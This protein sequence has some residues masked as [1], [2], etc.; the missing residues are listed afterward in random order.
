MVA[1]TETKVVILAAILL[2]LASLASY[3]Q[4]KTFTGMAISQVEDVAAPSKL[5]LEILQEKPEES[6]IH[7][8]VEEIINKQ[9]LPASLILQP[10]LFNITDSFAPVGATFPC[11]NTVTFDPAR[12]VYQF[13]CLV[14]NNPV[15]R[16]EIDVGHDWTQKG[17]ITIKEALSN[18]YLVYAGGIS[19]RDINGQEMGPYYFAYSSGATIQF[20]HQL[21]PN[22]AVRLWYRDTLQG[23]TTEKVYDY[24][25]M[26]KTLGLHAY[27]YN[28]RSPANGNY[29]YLFLAPTENTGNPRRVVIPYMDLVNM[30][31]FNNNNNYYF[32]TD[33]IDWSKSN[34][35]SVPLN[36]NWGGTPSSPT[37]ILNFFI[38]DYVPDAAG[39]VPPFDDTVYIT[40]STDPYDVMMNIHKSKPPYRDNVNPMVSFD[41]ETFP[42]VMGSTRS[43]S[44]F[45]NLGKILD[46]LYSFGLRDLWIT[47][48]DD[49]GSIDN[50][51]P[52]E[53]PPRIQ[54]GGSKDLKITAQNAQRY[55]Y[56]LG[57]YED[58]T[59]MQN[60]STYWN[61]S[62]L[63][64][65]PDETPR[66]S[67][68]SPAGFVNYR[69]RPELA[70]YYAS[71]NSPYFYDDTGLSTMYI[72]VLVTGPFYG[73]IDYS[74]SA[75][76]DA[77]TTKGVF[78]LNR[79]VIEYIR[80]VYQNPLGGEATVH[81]LLPISH[82][83]GTIETQE[84]EQY[85]GE[86]GDVVPD[87]ELKIVRPKLVGKGMGPPH[88]W[89]GC[90]F[91]RDAYTDPDSWLG[92]IG[93]KYR[94]TAVAYGR[95]GLVSERFFYEQPIPCTQTGCPF[96]YKM[97]KVL[98]KEYFMMKELQKQY[99]SANDVN[100]YYR[101]TAGNW[102]D[103]KQMIIENIELNKTQLREEYDNGL[104]VHVNRHPTNS[105][106]V[107][108][109]NSITYTLPPNS[110]IAW[111]ANI[112]GYNNYGTFL[113]FSALF[114]GRRVDY[115]NSPLYVMADGRGVL[116]DFGN[117]QTTYFK[118]ITSEVNPLFTVTE[119]PQ[120]NF[121]NFQWPITAFGGTDP[122][123]TTPVWRLQGLAIDPS[124][125]TQ[126]TNV[127]FYADGPQGFG[128]FI[129]GGVANDPR[130]T[131]PEFP[132]VGHGF[133]L[134]IP[135][136]RS[137]IYD[138]R[139][140]AIYGYTTDIDEGIDMPFHVRFI[141]IPT[142]PDSTPP[143]VYLLSPAN[144]TEE[145]A[146]TVYFTA[147]ARDNVALKNATLYISLSSYHSLTSQE[148]DSRWTPVQTVEL[149]PHREASVL[150]KQPD[151]P[152]EA[153]FDWNIKVCD[154]ANNCAFARDNNFVHLRYMTK[155]SIGLY[156]PV[157]SEVVTNQPVTFTAFISSGAPLIGAAL[158]TFINNQWIVLALNSTLTQKEETV[159]F[160]LPGVPDGVYI[161]NVRA[162]NV[163]G[164]CERAERGYFFQVLRDLPPVVTL[165]NPPPNYQTTSNTII[166]TTSVTDNGQLRDASLYADYSGQ[167][168]RVQTV[169]LSG[170]SASPS[171][172]VNNLPE[173]SF[174]WSVQSCDTN[175]N[176]AFA[177][178]NRTATIIATPPPLILP[179]VTL[180][181]PP[182]QWVLLDYNLLTFAGFAIS[183][184][185]L[186]SATVYTTGVNGQWQPLGSPIP[187]SGNA[188]YFSFRQAAP[189]LTPFKWN[190]LVCDNAVP[191][192]CGFAEKNHTASTSV[193]TNPLP[194]VS[195]VWPYNTLT[196]NKQPSTQAH[197]IAA[198]R[199]SGTLK[200][201]TLFYNISNEMQAVNVI[202]TGLT[203][204]YNAIFT[205][206][207]TPQTITLHYNVGACTIANICSLASPR[208]FYVT[209]QRG[210]DEHPQ[211]QITSPANGASLSSVTTVTASA[212][213]D[214]GIDRVEFSVDNNLRLTD[215][216]SPYSYSLDP[217]IL[218]PGY[219]LV[220]AKAFDTAGQFTAHQILIR[221]V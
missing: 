42:S 209:Y 216:T 195:V 8:S 151:L 32:M 34:S 184:R 14:N 113:T 175:G 177:P 41:F 157:N 13:S 64:R 121:N 192:A 102:V 164:E 198:I 119:N 149:T 67:W 74:A 141:N 110:Y 51:G 158:E 214:F 197:I 39:N 135:T 90:P 120:L 169:A 176:C 81:P 117:I 63:T 36:P 49:Y 206:P 65:N 173:R 115:I 180:V 148:R 38:A 139:P 71:L 86:C 194:G 77:K 61:L 155:P 2:I 163:I 21:M 186:A 182:D 154:F 25:I 16:Y 181:G 104:V 33:Y 138:G 146:K 205:L 92:S 127:K 165:V 40:L 54:L 200:N 68:T 153:K 29:K 60:A 111:N 137:D 37:S 80:S 53:Y 116:T 188:A 218:L 3:F 144:D 171:F 132:G 79:E 48:F 212:S 57:L 55:N 178:E 23:V 220:R 128:R 26:G 88:R 136:T 123:F 94:A 73:F 170:N 43:V 168:T 11:Q 99:L 5:P 124:F 50:A 217:S 10:P 4:G 9:E 31:V 85:R 87:F 58:Y 145:P 179:T 35:N 199:T 125:P 162:C 189:L 6:K 130:W 44:T 15:A 24:W 46:I 118:V 101:N 107:T 166:F 156:R 17:L 70:R 202:T 56:L 22:G 72:D 219:Y 215:R 98:F 45:A 103:L 108:A 204:P 221:R 82:Y 62:A 7:E 129:I 142:T 114:N 100:I 172:T 52:T 207:A 19:Y 140:H 47:Y 75:H 84:R 211:V 208:G 133:D 96:L 112:P 160:T 147:H 83:A 97:L 105:F 27:A 12:N 143:D 122:A 201:V 66:V 203:N 193:V 126:F 185:P 191:V 167:W 152:N 190:F 30:V 196:I 131:I 18:A 187:L 174:M 210:T 76:R 20:S 150:I 89:I 183:P 91:L 69:I 28:S 59:D 161:W 95:A 78:Q 134:V 109:P 159:F 106:S 93:D 213:D 1:S